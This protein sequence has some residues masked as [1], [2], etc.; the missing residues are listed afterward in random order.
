VRDS[1]QGRRQGGTIVVDLDLDAA[2]ANE[3][4][5]LDETRRERTRVR[6]ERH[7]L[8]D[9]PLLDRLH[10]DG[11]A[12]PLGEVV[13]QQPGWSAVKLPSESVAELG[14]HSL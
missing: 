11:R 14:S 8:A 9:E 4:D 10:R 6:R 7:G 3:A 12:E 5:L 2:G 1:R 13:D